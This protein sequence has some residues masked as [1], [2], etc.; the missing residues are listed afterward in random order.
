MR[1]EATTLTHDADTAAHASASTRTLMKDLRRQNRLADFRSLTFVVP[2]MLLIAAAFIVPMMLMLWRSVENTEVVNTLP[3]VSAQLQEWDPERS[4]LPNE[5]AFA[6]LASDIRVAREARTLG[7]AGRRLNLEIGGY[8]ELL[9]STGRSLDNAENAPPEDWKSV[10]TSIDPRWGETQYWSAIKRNTTSIT[11]FFFLTALDLRQGA[12]G[13][14][15]VPQE[16]RLYANTVVRTLAISLTV[17]VLCLFIAYPVAFT[18]ASASKGKANLLLFLVLLPFWTSI[19]VRSA[20]WIILLQRD[21]VV[22]SLLQGV[23]MINDPLELI[24]NRFGVVVALTHVLLPYMV[25]TLYSV[26]KGADSRYVRAARSLGAN[27]WQAFYRVYLPQTYAGIAAGSLLVFILSVG[28]YATPALI[29]GRADQM[30]AQSIAFNI[31]QTV[32]WGLAAALSV[33]LLILVLVLYAFYGKAS[34]IK[35]DASR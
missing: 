17:T 10:L 14:E 13:I 33:F 5:P 27:A 25:L 32:N 7:T 20:A 11:D 26:M 16:Q 15:L 31:N 1:L 2:C 28:S 30:I 21:G 23:G 4:V 12:T 22:N 18:I 34:A 9:I 24:F 3:T 6:A 35:T 8:L 19:L 29:G